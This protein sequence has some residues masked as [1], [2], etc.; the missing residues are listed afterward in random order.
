MEKNLKKLVENIS[1]KSTREIV[2]DHVNSIELTDSDEVIVMVDRRYA[3]NNLHSSEHIW[4][5][6]SWVRKAFWEDK[7]TVLKLQAHLMK[8]ETT[9]H[10][11]R[12]MNVPFKIHYR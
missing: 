1:P 2:E 4:N 10:H 12:E 3:F 11:D 7:E 6:I 5:L 8:W 9:E